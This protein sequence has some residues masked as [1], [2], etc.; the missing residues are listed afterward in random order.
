[1]DGPAAAAGPDF[2]AGSA[3][4]LVGGQKAP[5]GCQSGSDPA[6]V[7]HR[8]PLPIMKSSNVHALLTALPKCPS[9][10]DLTPVVEALARAC[11]QRT[12][13]RKS[14]AMH[15]RN[16]KDAASDSILREVSE[17]VT[18]LL[19]RGAAIT[20][21]LTR[22]VIGAWVDIS[23]AAIVLGLHRE[24]LTERVKQPK[25]R[26]L[27]GWPFWDG[28][29]W[30]FSTPAIDPTTRVEVLAR[31]PKHEPDAHAAMLPLWCS[32]QTVAADAPDAAFAAP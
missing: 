1:M 12:Q 7:Y 11:A 6:P 31:L 9:P 3:P 13:P 19:D 2:A 20:P 17:R 29:Q 4:P 15:V 21:V 10:D 28:H 16:A 26:Y 14:L 22:P 30:W 27:Y 25:Y 24:T 32:R 8:Q 18:Q 5:P 23:D